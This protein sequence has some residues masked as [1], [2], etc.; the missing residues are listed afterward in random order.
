MEATQR[1]PLIRSKARMFDKQK[2]SPLNW[3]ISLESFS[4]THMQNHSACVFIPC[5]PPPMWSL[6][7]VNLFFRVIGFAHH[8]HI[9]T[10][11]YTS[12]ITFSFSFLVFYYLSEAHMLLTHHFIF[13]L[14]N[15]YFWKPKFIQLIAACS[16]LNIKHTT[17]FEEEGQTTTSI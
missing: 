11:P 7:I 14:F 15:F 8:W 3:M 10:T 1:H 9:L 16:S 2:Y 13:L 12:P 4:M 5:L 17:S 6:S